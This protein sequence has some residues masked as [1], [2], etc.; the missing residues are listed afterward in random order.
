[1]TFA[2]LEAFKNERRLHVY[3]EDP[4]SEQ[5]QVLDVLARNSVVTIMLEV[6]AVRE[7]HL[8]ADSDEQFQV[9]LDALGNH[10]DYA[11]TAAHLGENLAIP[12]EAIPR[13]GALGSQVPVLE[14]SFSK[15]GVF[16]GKPRSSSLHGNSLDATA[17]DET[18]EV[19]VDPVIRAPS[20][21]VIEEGSDV[22]MLAPDTQDEVARG[23]DSVQTDITRDVGSSAHI[24]SEVDQV[25]KI[26]TPTV[27]TVIETAFEP[28]P[29]TEETKA[30]LVADAAAIEETATTVTG[31]T[32][33]VGT[34]S[35]EADEEDGGEEE[36][37][38]ILTPMKSEVVMPVEDT[39]EVYKNYFSKQGHFF[40]NWKRRYFVLDNGILYY[41]E[42]D[43][44]GVNAICK[45]YV[46]IKIHQITPPHYLQILHMARG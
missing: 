21:G 24:T 43:I 17:E 31:D 27:E 37:G 9:W 40:K 22:A 6:G 45:L 42:K 8:K 28:E 13:S 38:I 11:E 33:S 34:A 36:D 46:Y 2:K 20:M 5:Q 12:P 15:S 35:T 19:D 10:I 14:R 18:P 29:A 23:T 30:E 7:L 16:T 41:Y 44:P 26:D 25:D 1:M 3:F 39:V 32:R 4:T